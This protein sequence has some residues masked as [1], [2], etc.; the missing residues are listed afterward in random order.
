MINE[1]I[2]LVAI[3]IFLEALCDVK[4]SGEVW[5]AYLLDVSG[6]GV[7]AVAATTELATTLAGGGGGCP[8]T[9]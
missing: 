4:L 8:W 1:C 9:G 2:W 5:V 6:L 7:W 3:F